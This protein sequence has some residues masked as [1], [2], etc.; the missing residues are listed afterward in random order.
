LL[1]VFLQLYQYLKNDI[2]KITKKHLDFYY[3]QVLEIQSKIL[4]PDSVYVLVNINP[5]AGKIKIN[6][7]ELLEASNKDGVGEFFIG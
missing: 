7:D 1:L 5:E 4:I 2:N 6:K 3:R